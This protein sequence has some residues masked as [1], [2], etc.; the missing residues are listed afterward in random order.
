MKRKIALSFVMAVALA[1]ATSG[2]AM[3]DTIARWDYNT[4]VTAPSTGSGTQGTLADPAGGATVTL[5]SQ[6]PAPTTPNTNSDPASPDNALKI[7]YSQINNVNS[8]VTWAVSTVGF[9]GIGVSFDI[10]RNTTTTPRYYTVSYS[11]DGGSTWLS[12]ASQIDLTTTMSGWHNALTFDLSSFSGVSNNANFVFRLFE[13]GQPGSSFTTAYT[14]IDYV[15][16][17]GAPVPIP[18]AAWLLGSGLLGLVA[19]RRR[20]KK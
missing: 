1:L 8:G 18:A 15:T 16:F 2:M 9:T 12:A 3:A 14:Y 20:M 4:S 6:S 5:S 19:I 10:Y 13:D 7:A 17:T 11:T